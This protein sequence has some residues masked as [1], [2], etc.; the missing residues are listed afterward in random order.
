MKKIFVSILLCMCFF[1]V[2]QAQLPFTPIDTNFGTKMLQLPQ[3]YEFSTLLIGGVDS[4]VLANGTKQLA[5][6]SQDLIVFIPKNGS[7][8]TEGTL[9]VSHETN[10]I[11]AVRGNDGGATIM[12]I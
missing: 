7:S 12:D 11:D 4:V 9:F 3:G 10:G 1:G 5:R 2:V 6:E 8:S